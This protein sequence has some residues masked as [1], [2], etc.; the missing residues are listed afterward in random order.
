[1]NG[2]EQQRLKALWD[3]AI[4][5]A[6]EVGQKS[7]EVSM[8][9]AKELT[10]YFEKISFGSGAIITALVS[11]IGG[12]RNHLRPAWLF[13]VSLAI[14]FL[15]M[16]G[17]MLRNWRNH[18][19]P[20]NA[21]RRQRIEADRNAKRCQND[22]ILQGGAYS[23]QTGRPIN[24]EEWSKGFRAS[25]GKLSE[26]LEYLSGYEAKVFRQVKTTEHLTLALA[27]IGMMQ[28]ITLAWINF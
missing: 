10:Q 22:F 21:L 19:Y 24:I 27:L 6:D 25:D 2:Q 13:R 15:V 26:Q 4:N 28:L 16:F 14:W 3:N 5:H 17:A 11:F 8:D 1:M 20:V 18:Y 12:T 7:V 9:V 23:F